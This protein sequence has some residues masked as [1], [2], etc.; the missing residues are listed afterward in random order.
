MKKLSVLLAVAIV[1]VFNL[2]AV[3]QDEL[4]EKDLLEITFFGGLGVP[5]GGI[6]D[7]HNNVPGAKVGF[8]FGLGLGYFVKPNIV[9]GVDLGFGQF[10]TDATGDASQAEGTNHRLFN[11]NLFLKYYFVG[12]SNFE[13]FIKAHVGV[14][15]AKFTTRRTRPDGSYQAISYSP[16]LAYGLGLGLFYYSA[17]YSGLYLEAD[18]H[19]ANTKNSERV[20][21]Q[22]TV[23]FGENVS[24][25][26]IRAGIRVLVGTGE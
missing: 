11:P 20:Y 7:A 13:P 19:R 26:S 5:T 12:E 16:A 4:E 8:N 18:Y 10:A 9:L 6:S 1:L 22:E 3:A 15:N 14:E 2:S 17:D 21:D 24:V 23:V 25:L